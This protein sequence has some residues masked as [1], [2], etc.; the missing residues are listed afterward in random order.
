MG[1]A[2]EFR[3]CNC[4]PAPKLKCDGFATDTFILSVAAGCE[5]ILKSDLSWSRLAFLSAANGCRE[6]GLKE[7]RDLFMLV[8]DE[9]KN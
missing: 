9:R 8:T 1:G 2:N 3:G 5:S 6:A 7:W 4:N